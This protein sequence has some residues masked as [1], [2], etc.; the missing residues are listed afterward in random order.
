[1]SSSAIRE[2]LPTDMPGSEGRSENANPGS[3]GTT[4][5][6]AGFPFVNN[7]RIRVICTKVAGQP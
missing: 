2:N 7:G 4:T 3:D 6:K 5:S 1:M